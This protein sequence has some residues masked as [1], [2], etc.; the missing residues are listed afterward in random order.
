MLTEKPEGCRAMWDGKKFFL[1]PAT[2]D[3]VQSVIPAH[4]LSVAPPQWFRYQLPNDTYLDG[5]LQHKTGSMSTLRSILQKK[6]IEESEWEGINFIVLDSPD[7]KI[8]DEPYEIRLKSIARLLHPQA[9]QIKVVQTERCTGVAHLQSYFKH[10]REHGGSGILLHHDTAP[11]VPGYKTFKW[12]VCDC[13]HSAA[14]IHR[15]KGCAIWNGARGLFRRR[16]FTL[17]QVCAHG[18]T[19]AFVLQLKQLFQ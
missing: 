19:I 16:F 7:H 8:R 12:Q 14:F 9:Q 13:P 17:P 3:H 11:Y 4:T 18:D 5:V 6:H 15:L 10:V 2:V 1:K